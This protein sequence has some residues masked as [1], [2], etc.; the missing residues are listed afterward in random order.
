M[1]WRDTFNHFNP[2]E[3]LPHSM[4]VSW[5]SERLLSALIILRAGTQWI[6]EL[7]VRSE[8]PF[9]QKKSV[10]LINRM[11]FLCLLLALPG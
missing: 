2:T 11:S 3:D 5:F 1:E 10:A 4:R 6:C 8:M 7:G 9:Y